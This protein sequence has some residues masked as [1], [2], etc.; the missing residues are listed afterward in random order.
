MSVKVL[1]WGTAAQGACA[2]Y[3]G[4]LYDQPLL[5]LGV[6]LRHID[7]LPTRLDLRDKSGKFKSKNLSM[8]ELQK[9]LAAGE[10]G[11][12]Y[13][14]DTEALNWADVIMFRRYYV[15]HFS[16]SRGGC[17]FR[18]HDEVV[19]RAHP[20]GI[21]AS[22]PYVPKRDDLTR[23]VWAMAARQK[24]KGILYETD[25]LLLQGSTTRWNG[26]WP[27]M[28][29]QEGLVRQM[30]TR[31]DL[32]TVTTPTLA[33]YMRQLNPRTRVIRN[34]IN[35]ELY[36]ADKPRP[37]G[38]KARLVYYG[39]TVR[40]RDYGGCLDDLTGKF[41]GGYPAAS[42][43]DHKSQL[44]TV[45]IGATPE[46][47]SALKPFFQ[48]LRPYVSN[49][50]GFARE[51]GN[52]HP[53]IGVAPVLGVG[54][55]D[56]CKSELHWLEYTAAGAATIATR[57]PGGPDSGPYNVI[58]ND[59]DGVLAKGRQ[60]WSDGLK[61]LL[62][63]SRREDIAAA[64]KERVTDEYDYRKRALAWKDAFE[65]VSEHRGIGGRAA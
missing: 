59:V 48:E 24:D 22:S 13:T 40:M 9:Q 63:K 31:A 6:E 39:S 49:I 14:V 52:T 26:L 33:K 43:Q 2:Y 20:H 19:A 27:D 30:A 36:V 58:R 5:E 32:V 54:G 35:P 44:H 12:S 15:T 51:L 42:V 34:A 8:P 38:D 28:A 64:A 60:E 16:C 47:V 41:V 10:A 23:H 61:L 4:H 56:S 57:Y 11:A 55:F 45:F 50:E 46:Y 53:D 25:D 29:A 17:D 1:V 21:K 62:D 18:T 37:E 65:W 7:K 3:R